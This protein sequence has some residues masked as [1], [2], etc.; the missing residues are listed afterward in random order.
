MVLIV[1]SYYSHVS[2]VHLGIKKTCHNKAHGEMH[3]MAQPYLYTCMLY[4][5]TM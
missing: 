5:E 2:R 3:I 1:L 4:I